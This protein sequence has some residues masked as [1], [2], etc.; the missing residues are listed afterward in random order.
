[1][2][3]HPQIV[4]CWAE[5]DRVFQTVLR[6]APAAASQPAEKLLSHFAQ[7]EYN[8]IDDHLRL[9]VIER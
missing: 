1:M 2:F 6:L 7:H 9:Q 3:A 5:A 4:D 8:A